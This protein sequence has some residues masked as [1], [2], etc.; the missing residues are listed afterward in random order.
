VEVS[1]EAQP[2]RYRAAIAGGLLGLIVGLGAAPSLAHPPAGGLSQSGYPEWVTAQLRAKVSERRA[3]KRVFMMAL[4]AVAVLSVAVACHQ[5]HRGA[6]RL[7]VV[8]G[9]GVAGLATGGAAAL[10][11]GAVGGIRGSLGWMLLPLGGGGAVVGGL[12]GGALAL[13]ATRRPGTTRAVAALTSWGLAVAS[14][15]AYC[16]WTWGSPSW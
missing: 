14:S 3:T 10:W 8:V 5:R 6:S 11:I 15:V 1:M 12:L 9:G 7:V 16:A 13:A 4:S 2:P